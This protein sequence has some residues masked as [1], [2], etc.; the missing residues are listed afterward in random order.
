MNTDD[1]FGDDIE[2]GD[3]NEMNGESG[4]GN[5]FQKLLD[6]LNRLDDAG[7]HYQCEHQSEDALMVIVSNEGERWEIEFFAD[8]EVQ[9]EVF[10][11]VSEDADLENEEALERL[12]LD[13]FDEDDEDED[14]D[15]SYEDED[16]FELTDE[17]DRN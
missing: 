6:F 16:D 11:S 5:S 8:G 15:E 4:N 17:E 1:L 14:E 13:D 7:F 10:Y 3:E 9:V 2:D 12:F